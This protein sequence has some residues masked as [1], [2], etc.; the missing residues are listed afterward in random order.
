MVRHDMTRRLASVFITGEPVYY[1][2]FA[3]IKAAVG[4]AN[5]FLIHD[6][7]YLFGYILLLLY[8][9]ILSPTHLPVPHLM[10]TIF[11]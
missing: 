11:F 8:V 10:Y 3:V 9:V 5:D 7:S 6:F 2:P 4:L 1:A